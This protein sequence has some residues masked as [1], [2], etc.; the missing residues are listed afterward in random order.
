MSQWCSGCHYP[1]DPKP[2]LIIDA[3]QEAGFEAPPDN[4]NET[5]SR[6]F[7]HSGIMEQD[8]SDASC[9]SCHGGLLSQNATTKEFVHNVKEGS[10]GPDCV[11]CHDVRETGSSKHVDFTAAA[12]GVHAQL[13]NRT[14]DPSTS[15]SQ[16]LSENYK[17]WACH[18]TQGTQPEGMGDRYSE[19]YTCPDCHTDNGENWGRYGSAPKV[20]E[21]YKEGEEV[22][23]ATDANTTV[24]SCLECHTKSEMIQNNS[25]SDTGSFDTDG[26]GVKGGS[27]NYYHYGKDR[28]D[29]QT[30]SGATDCT[31]CHQDNDTAFK[32]AMDNNS[33]YHSQMPDHTDREGGPTCRDCHGGEVRIHDTNLTK[34]ETM[35]SDQF[36]AQGCHGDAGTFQNKPQPHGKAGP[37][38]NNLNCTDCHTDSSAT[39]EKQVH[40]IRN[41][42]QD[43]SISAQH[44]ESN[45]AD[46]Q[47]CHQDGAVSS[48]AG[49]SAP[50][51]IPYTLNHSQR[52]ASGTHWNSTVNGYLG[53]WDPR[54][55][56]VNG[57]NYCHG[58]T[59]SSLHNSTSL[60]KVDPAYVG[61]QSINTVISETSTYWCG[62]CHYPDNPYYDQIM[63]EFDEAGLD[64]P[65]NN[66]APPGYGHG[67]YLSSDQSDARCAECHSDLLS[68]GT[69]SRMDEFAHNV[70]YGG[71]GGN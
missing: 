57:C 66:D 69:S 27:Q 6:F 29:I 7:D 64:R 22:K 68:G 44:D 53:P 16:D 1:G 13:N 32:S 61:Q 49:K 9:K 43:G 45:A 3:I 18:D 51:Q 12:N 52:S 11:S 59:Q 37:N 55:N 23:A 2:S 20:S 15:A 28:T 47:T 39:D 38:E 21:H 30:G 54:E 50:P 65:P 25:D 24:K 63:A 36:C 48:V 62:S 71:S 31:Y 17:C 8:S 70:Y 26:D 5:G 34:P 41:I 67:F 46:C 35:Y 56:N 14:G 33:A 40:G 10:G 4:T 58:D 42:E 60:G 19:P